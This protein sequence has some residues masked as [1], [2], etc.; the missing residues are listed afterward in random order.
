[1]RPNW[2]VRE[3]L[4][5]D[6]AARAPAGRPTLCHLDMAVMPPFPVRKGREAISF[7]RLVP[8]DHAACVRTRTETEVLARAGVEHSRV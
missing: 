5:A 3:F 6:W 4:N 1:M 8:G 2:S 7:R